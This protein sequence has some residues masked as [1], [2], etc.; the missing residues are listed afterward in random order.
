VAA[1]G[2]FV[3]KFPHSLRIRVHHESGHRLGPHF[4][5]R[6]LVSSRGVNHLFWVI[7]IIACPS[8]LF[9]VMKE[10]RLTDSS[11]HVSLS[12]L[13]GVHALARSLSST[14]LAE[15]MKAQKGRKTAM[16]RKKT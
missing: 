11:R 4:L 6:W 15:K 12:V 13:A 10:P 8:H 14:R 3:L 16:T 9:G 2:A 1:S 7:W 5:L